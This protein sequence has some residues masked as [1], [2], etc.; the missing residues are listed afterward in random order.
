MDASL[1]NHTTATS[2][3]PVLSEN[4]SRAYF[5]IVFTTDY[6][7]RVVQR[8]ALQKATVHL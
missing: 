1:T 3:I 8:R 7:W 6:C 5:L 4:D 2:M